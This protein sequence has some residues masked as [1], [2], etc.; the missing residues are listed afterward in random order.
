MSL[1]P[2]SLGSVVLGVLLLLAGCARGPASGTPA[3]GTEPITVIDAVGRTVS[4]EAPP[5][6]IVIAGRANFMINDAVYLFPEASER[7]V[8]LTQAQQTT[9]PFLS[10]LDPDFEEKT[11]FVAESTAEEIAAANPDLVFLKRFMRESVGNSLEAIGIPVVYLDLE[12]PE[13]YEREIQMLGT[14]F[15]NPERAAQIGEFYGSRLER[16]KMGLESLQGTSAPR[17]LVLQ[18]NPRGGTVALETPPPGWIQTQM[19]QLTGGDPVWSDVAQGGWTVVNLEQIS[20]WNPD[21][22]FVISYFED[23][24]AVVE[25][26]TTDPNWQ[27]LQAVAEQQVFAFPKDF[28]S[29]DQPDTRWILGTLWMAQQ[30]HPDVFAEIDMSEEIMQFYGELYGLDRDTIEAEVLPLLEGDIER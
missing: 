23:G 14:I 7:V 24:E 3:A 8:A 16:I 21:R 20:A 10:L 12:T 26:L 22:I 28:Y 6:R 15:G 18:Y 1:S 9:V 2:K 11:L 25:R 5:E 17:A 19:V 27:G 13:Q 29:W 30:M 4:W